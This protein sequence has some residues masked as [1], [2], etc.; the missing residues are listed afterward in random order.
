MHSWK[1]DHCL[2]D[3][4][5]ASNVES[6]QEEGECAGSGGLLTGE[7]L[8][9]NFLGEAIEKML[10]LLNSKIK[11]LHAFHRERTTVIL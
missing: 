11:F 6:V 1:P 2:F 7:E 4:A 10:Y 5:A 3:I 9:R 8:L